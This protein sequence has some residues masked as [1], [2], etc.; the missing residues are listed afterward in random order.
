M[1][2][3]LS[4][5]PPFKELHVRGTK[6]PFK[7]LSERHRVRYPCFSILKHVVKSDFFETLNV[8]LLQ[9]AYAVP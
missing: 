5:Q 6:A 1:K 3:M 9:I 8:G 2:T 7:Y 4:D